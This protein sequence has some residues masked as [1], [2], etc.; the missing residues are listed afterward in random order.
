MTGEHVDRQQSLELAVTSGDESNI[1]GLLHDLGHQMMTLSLLAE[2]LQAALPENLQSARD[3]R[4]HA[5]LV[6]Q[7]T[8]RAMAMIAG[9]VPPSEEVSIPCPAPEQLIDARDIAAKVAQLSG[10]GDDDASVRLLPGPATFMSVDPML[11]WR[12]ACNLVDNAVRAAGAGGHVEISVYRGA[13][14]VIE[15]ADDGAGFGRGPHGLAGRGLTVVMQLVAATGGELE[16]SAGRGGGTCARA[17]FGS[18]C[19]RILLPRP[20]SGQEAA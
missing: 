16:V 17:T 6:R 15:V 8:T 12:V 2:S 3:A 18:R 19:D 9:G 7:E 20:R 10:L 14:T 11:V 4:Q 1:R 5:E 13:G